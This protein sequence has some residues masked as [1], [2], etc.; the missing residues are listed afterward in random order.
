MLAWGAE[1]VSRQAVS[2]SAA[3]DD[4]R[5]ARQQKFRADSLFIQKR[6]D[7]AAQLYWQALTLAPD[8]FN[9]NEKFQ[10]AKRLIS[11]GRSAE[12]SETLRQL[13]AE[14]PGNVPVRTEFAHVLFALSQVA[15]ASREA[16]QIL[17]VDPANKEAAEL[18]A[19]VASLFSV[20]KEAAERKALGDEFYQSKRFQQ[21]AKAYIE[22]LFVMDYDAKVD[23]KKLMAERVIDS[24]SAD[25]IVAVAE[26]II[27]EQPD[28]VEAR[29]RL[30][31]GLNVLATVAIAQLDAVVNSEATSTSDG[32]RVFSGQARQ[33]EVRRA[34][35]RSV[36]PARKLQAAN[37]YLE[38]MNLA[39][40]AIEPT[41]KIRIARWLRSQNRVGDALNILEA[42]VDNQP[43]NI[44]ARFELARTRIALEQY[45]AAISDID[46][47]LAIDPNRRDALLMKAGAF[48]KRGQV[49]AAIEQYLH[50][51]KKDNGAD[52]RL[53]L[54]HSLVAAGRRVEAGTVLRE[55]VTAD[56]SQQE[57]LQEAAVNLVKTTRPSVEV[58]QSEY[59]D[60]DN[61]ASTNIAF[62]VKGSVGDY[63]LL[64]NFRRKSADGA[65]KI[66]VADTV[67]ATV[68]T[69]VADAFKV[70]GRLG[71]TQLG[72]DGDAATTVGQL[73]VD[74][75]LAETSIGALY[76]QETLT[77]N[78]ALIK[79]NIQ[80]SQ[81][82]INVSQPLPYRMT[83]KG[84]YTHKEFSDDNSG[85]DYLA[86]IH[87]LLNRGSPALGV[88]YGYH[89]ANYDH[90][91][92]K[93]YF[94]PQDFSANQLMLTG[95]W[96]SDGYYVYFSMDLGRQTMW[97]N[98]LDQRPHFFA[99]GT[100]TAGKELTAHWTVELNAEWSNSSGLERPE[101]YGD[102][103][104]G[105]RIS[106]T[107]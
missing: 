16:D 27:D 14:Q 104:I 100:A 71:V 43:A 96:E 12:A 82:S 91:G 77:A 2:A 35:E 103:M 36:T 37:L 58:S 70:S 26:R 105:G 54:F 28:E 48:R 42:L 89:I 9:F 7:D 46:E 13:V 75:R 5:L 76:L 45:A 67:T 88:G 10:I 23:E 99:Y 8:A 11:A 50:L 106:Y 86:S 30:A 74:F 80:L 84:A 61:S 87:Y 62:G 69:N 81:A 95:N 31:T 4:A 79:N 85:D 63:D 18:K 47:I 41:E 29:V 94:D 34:R 22:A 32:E 90:P 102:S 60:S 64:A 72:P 38:S 19:S 83:L 6:V 57:E 15:A 73:K 59:G 92:K 39:P 44:E 56:E 93:G 21:A 52:A 1:P 65:T 33:K 107:F 66:F 98:G 20:N 25:E 101:V 51:V 68:V 3:A 40:N 49:R 53:G 24:L 78:A 97:R 17:K 55:T